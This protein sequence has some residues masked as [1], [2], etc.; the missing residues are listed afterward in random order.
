[1]NI[2]AGRET[3][4]AIAEQVGWSIKPD[5]GFYAVYDADGTLVDTGFESVFEARTRIPKFT[6]SVD[7]A[8]SLPF[9]S[10][11]YLFMAMGATGRAW[12]TPNT[13]GSAQSYDDPQGSTTT[14]LLP[15]ERIALAVCKAWLMWKQTQLVE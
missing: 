5:R 3:D 4:Q 15:Q 12:L 2:T 11:Q 14:G 13:D 7:A 9:P 6:T 1:M 10:G 8:L